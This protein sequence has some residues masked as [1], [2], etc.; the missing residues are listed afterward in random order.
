MPPDSTFEVV[1]LG[2]GCG[3]FARYFLKSFAD[4]C[5]AEKRDWFDRLVYFV[6]DASRRT[7]EQWRELG[8]FADFG[9]V[10]IG[11][12]DA[13]WPESARNLDGGPMRPVSLRCVIAN[14]VLDVLPSTFVR[15]GSDG[16][17]ELQVR[18]NL[19]RSS[20]LLRTY[21]TQTPDAIRALAAS[22]NPDARASL[23][24]LLPTFEIEAAFQ[25]LSES[26]SPEMSAALANAVEGEP[27]IVNRAALQ[28][29][30]RWLGL[31]AAGGFM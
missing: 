6:T 9:R 21:T 1:E 20:E 17:E 30:E 11:T 22:N 26:A 24:K 31:A 5:D 27:V 2:A 7:V 25:Q 16:A 15:R 18:T 19:I 28:A 29:I 4:L 12:C 8:I 3:L 23:V 14:Y 10:E 13:S